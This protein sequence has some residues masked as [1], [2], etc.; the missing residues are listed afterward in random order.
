MTTERFRWLRTKLRRLFR[1]G[2]QEAEL[3]AEMQFHFDQLV[4]EFEAEGMSKRQA[5]AAANREFGTTDSY[6]EEVRDA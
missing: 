3:D 5:T 4:A 2:A 1:R 6:R